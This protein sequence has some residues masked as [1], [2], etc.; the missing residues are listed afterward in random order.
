MQDGFL[1]L[2]KI[3]IEELASKIERKE[4]AKEFNLTEE[5]LDLLIKKMLDKWLNS[6]DF[7]L[8]IADVLGL[9]MPRKTKEK[10]ARYIG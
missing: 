5:Q 1:Q 8:I 3:V 2:K 9:S 4:L 6:T 10:R 7:I